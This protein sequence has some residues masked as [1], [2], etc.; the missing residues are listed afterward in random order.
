MVWRRDWILRWWTPERHI[1]QLSQFYWKVQSNTYSILCTVLPIGPLYYSPP[2]G[3]RGCANWILS[4]EKRCSIEKGNP[5]KGSSVVG[6]ITMKRHAK[7]ACSGH[8]CLD[9]GEHVVGVLERS[10]RPF[11]ETVKGNPYAL[12]TYPFYM[13][14]FDHFMDTLFPR[15]HFPERN[16]GKQWPKG[17]SKFLEQLYAK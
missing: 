1:N 12:A 8:Y 13:Q 7:T 3:V 5:A 2:L 15:G 14:I 4:T 9:G 16:S 17:T 10:L 11:T 6:K